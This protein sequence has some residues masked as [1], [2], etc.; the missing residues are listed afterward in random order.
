[1]FLFLS[2]HVILKVLFEQNAI[3][4]GVTGEDQVAGLV[5]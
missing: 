1:M 2:N 3:E 4:I 5:L